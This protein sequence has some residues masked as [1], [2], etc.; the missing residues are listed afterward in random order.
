[1][2]SRILLNAIA[3]IAIL[4]LVSY[5]FVKM[6]A[7]KKKYTLTGWQKIVIILIASLTSFILMSFSVNLPQQVKVDMRYNGLV[8]LLYYIGPAVFVPSTIVTAFLRLSWGVSSAAVYAFILYV[9][10]SI[11]LPFLIKRLSKHFNSY[12]T[13][14]ILNAVYVIGH[15]IG[16]YFVY[17]D[18]KQTLFI[19]FFNFLF[20]SCCL[21]INIMFIEDMRVNVQRYLDEKER[22]KSD[23]LTGLYNKREFSRNWKEIEHDPKVKHTAFLMLD[24]DHFKCIIDQ[25][26]HVNGDLVL[27]QVADLLRIQNIEYQHAY[28]VGGEEFCIILKNLCFSEQKKIAERIRVSIESKQFVLENRQA[29]Q[30]TVSIGLASSY[31]IKDMKKLYRLADRALYQAKERGRNQIVALEFEE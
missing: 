15:S 11:V 24:I 2:L 13:G 4:T 17:Y 18:W 7:K 9:I 1:M 20:S 3:N 19:S 30:V 14:L 6:I 28:R 29:I 31:S 5:I 23:Y 27:R 26:G 8:L 16:L 12:A 21:M 10:L 22:A 25:Y